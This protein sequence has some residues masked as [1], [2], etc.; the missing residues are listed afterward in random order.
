MTEQKLITIF[1]ET[2]TKQVVR[3]Q[4]GGHWCKLD[5]VTGRIMD[6]SHEILC[7]NGDGWEITTTI[8]KIESLSFA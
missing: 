2:I 8:S 7:T 5:K 1:N 3:V 4:V 6:D